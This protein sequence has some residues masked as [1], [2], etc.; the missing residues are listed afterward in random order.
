MEKLDK[1]QQI[2]TFLF[3]ND[4]FLLLEESIDLEAALRLLGCKSS[5]P[6]CGLSP[7]LDFCEA[8]TFGRPFSSSD[9]RN[10]SHFLFAV[11]IVSLQF[12]VASYFSIGTFPIFCLVFV[13][14]YPYFI[15]LQTFLT[16]LNEYYRKQKQLFDHYKFVLLKYLKLPYFLV[17][18]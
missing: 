18:Q 9:F 12:I 13:L 15:W 10:L 1:F 4:I 8:C 14:R 2:I 5:T 11:A 3:S 6:Q 16:E 7:P 17:N